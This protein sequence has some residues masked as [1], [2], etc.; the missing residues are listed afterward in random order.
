M[1]VTGSLGEDLTARWDRLLREM[2]S[3]AAGYRDAGYETAAVHP[4]DVSVISAPEQFGLVAIVDSEEFER[5]TELGVAR[6][7]GDRQV[8]I[9]VGEDVVLVALAVERRDNAAVVLVPL[10]YRRTPDE[11]GVFRGHETLPV[12]IRPRSGDRVVTFRQAS[13]PFL[14]SDPF[15]A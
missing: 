1:T 4:V 13:E 14:P 9:E 6:A 12:R 11:E 7:D 2:E 8:S 15:D 5:V 3:T 10:Y